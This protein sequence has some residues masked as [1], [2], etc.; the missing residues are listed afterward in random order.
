MVIPIFW[1]STYGI[2]FVFFFKNLF[3]PIVLIGQSSTA[4]VCVCVFERVVT[5]DII[6]ISF[7]VVVFLVN[8]FYLN[9]NEWWIEPQPQH[10]IGS[11]PLIG[12]CDQ[13]NNNNN[14]KTES[15]SSPIKPA[16]Q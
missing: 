3:V 6:I 1:N 4:F 15:P 8:Q 12:C 14:N 9:E 5:H 11:F 13:H 7:I 2:W 16:N 10:T